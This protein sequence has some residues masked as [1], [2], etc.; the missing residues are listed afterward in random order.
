M[1]YDTI[2]IKP[3]L[4]GEWE[5]LHRALPHDRKKGEQQ[6]NAT[7]GFFHYPRK[8]GKEKAFRMLRDRMIEERFNVI[9]DL[10]LQINKLRSLSL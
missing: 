10:I 1:L 4:N 2:E 8:M 9:I 3:T 7:L 6:L 5:V